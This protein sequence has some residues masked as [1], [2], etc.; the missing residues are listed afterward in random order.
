MPT[1]SCAAPATREK[2]NM[3]NPAALP[4]GPPARKQYQPMTTTPEH[5]PPP[6]G[7][8]LTA[9]GEHLAAI[10]AG[11]S[12]HELTSR[13]DVL[14]GTPVLTIDQSAG[15]PDP[16]TIAIEPGCGPGLRLECTC[17]WSPASGAAP[18]A[19]AATIAGM[20]AA[21]RPARPGPAAADPGPKPQAAASAPPT[22]ARDDLTPRV[23]R[24][25]YAEFELHAVQ[26]TA[27][28]AVPTGTAWYPG[29][30]I[31]EIAQQISDPPSPDPPGTAPGAPTLAGPGPGSQHRPHPQSRLPA[32]AAP[33]PAAIN[34]WPSAAPASERTP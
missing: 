8:Q 9:A 6:A 20:L 4:P 7:H 3:R 24:A 27:Y 28:V 33:A 29:R 19:T 34:A 21:L 18:E 31:S 26:D 1:R 2:R 30:S 11:L 15:G 17:T 10:A 32:R 23:F 5:E 13:L 22:A 14:G 12:G 25:L 16:A